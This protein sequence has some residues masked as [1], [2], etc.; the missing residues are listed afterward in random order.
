MQII[1]SGKSMRFRRA[2]GQLTG[3][4]AS[5]VGDT[6]ACVHS[7]CLQ[8]T[9]ATRKRFKV[10]SLEYDNMRFSGFYIDRSGSGFNIHQRPYID[11]LNL[12]PSDRYFVLLRQYRSKLSGLIHIHPN[13]CVVTSKHAQVTEKSFNISLVK[14][15]NTTKRYL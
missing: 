10:R 4:L 15:Y 2:R 6:L 13:V 12:F 11:R 3:L 7:S 9:E 14:Q 1:A 5:Y 8:L